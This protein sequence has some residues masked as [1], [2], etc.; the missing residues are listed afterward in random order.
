[1]VHKMHPTLADS[2]PL[3]RGKARMGVGMYAEVSYPHRAKLLPLQRLTPKGDKNLFEADTAYSLRVLASPA[4]GGGIIFRQC[5]EQIY[6]AE[7]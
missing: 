6:H 2:F 4:Q 7:I 5:G 1:M 3:P